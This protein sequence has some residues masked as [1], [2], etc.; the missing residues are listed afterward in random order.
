MIP[1]YAQ[2]DTMITMEVNQS[3]LT[4]IRTIRLFAQFQRHLEELS[5]VP[6]FIS[7]DSTRRISVRCAR[8]WFARLLE[9]IGL[10]FIKVGFQSTSSLSLQLISQSTSLGSL[11]WWIGIFLI[12][13]MTQSSWEPWILGHIM[14]HTRSKVVARRAMSALPRCFLQ[15]AK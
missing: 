11:N 7:W 14:R 15:L 3:C 13:K 4:T 2:L 6:T 10:Q 12:Q 5:L 9:V 8:K 1:F